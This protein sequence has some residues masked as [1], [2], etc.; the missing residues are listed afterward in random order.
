MAFGTL[1]VDCVY[2]DIIVYLSIFEA[3]ISVDHFANLSW[4]YD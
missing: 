1:G 2:I 3:Y 4:R